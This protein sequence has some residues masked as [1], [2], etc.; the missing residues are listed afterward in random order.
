MGA[1]RHA[2]ARPGRRALSAPPTVPAG[3]AF[4][5]GERHGDPAT[6]VVPP[7]A[8]GRG[9]V[10]VRPD[11]RAVVLGSAQ[12]DDAVDPGACAAAGVA[13]VR[14]RSGGGAVLVGP[15]EQVWLD[16]FVPAGDRRFEADVSRA[17]WWLGELWAGA[18]DDAGVAGAAVLK[19]PLVAGRHGRVVCF[20]GLGPGEVTL[21]GRKLVGISQR[22]DRSG[23]W[24]FSM[25]TCPAPAGAAG[26]PD[27]LRLDA[28]D[29]RQLA[30]DLAASTTVLR[31]DAGAVEQAL[32]ARLGA[33]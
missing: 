13:V 25:A 8:T 3:G 10:L 6:L 23:A 28:G 33:A 29:R 12:R 1:V 21:A 2:R 11:R 18:L 16:V 24:L 15:G 7:P 30:D 31:V 20:A 27:L 32:A 19:G 17:A 22:R 26:L 4:L 5:L 14:R 9:A